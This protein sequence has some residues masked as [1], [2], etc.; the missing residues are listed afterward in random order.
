MSFGGIAVV[1]IFY[2]MFQSEKLRERDFYYFTFIRSAKRFILLVYSH[3]SANT[4][5][6]TFGRALIF[7]RVV[8]AVGYEKTLPGLGVS[9]KIPGTP[10]VL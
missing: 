5:T 1:S 8:S 6:F 4:F 7:Q 10:R 9:D 3:K 2:I